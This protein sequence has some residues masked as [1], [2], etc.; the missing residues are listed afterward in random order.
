M[1]SLG[2]SLIGVL[3]V[4]LTEA[5]VTHRLARAFLGTGVLGGFTTFSTCAMHTQ[6]LVQDGHPVLG[7]VY[8]TS[9]PLV[10]LVAVLVTATATRG[11]SPEGNRALLGPVADIAGAAFTHARCAE[12]RCSL[13]AATSS[14]R[15]SAASGRFGPVTGPVVPGGW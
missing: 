4:V 3:M 2:S 13:A 1:N 9:T 10:A 15:L 7:L 8:L 5:R 14:E 12:E 6:Q 11:H